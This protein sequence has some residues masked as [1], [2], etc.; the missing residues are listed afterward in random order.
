M[1]SATI[2]W[3]RMDR[4]GHESARLAGC[5]DIDHNFSPSTNVLPIQRLAL[6]TSGTR[7]VDRS[8]TRR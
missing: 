6:G 8:R 4:P 2:L 5:I 1:S 7:S 3:R